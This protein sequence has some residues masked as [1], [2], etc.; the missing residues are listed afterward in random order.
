MRQAGMELRAHGH[1]QAAEEVFDKALA[2]LGSRPVQESE[3]AGHRFL[4]AWTLYGADRWEAARALAEELVAESPESMTY[5]GFLGL[6][7][8][9]QGDGVLAEEQARWL[10]ELQPPFFPSS[11]LVWRARIAS[12]S[13][14][15]D[16]AMSL[17]RQAFDR[18]FGWSNRHPAYHSFEPL[19]D[20]PEYQE[21]MRPTG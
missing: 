10:A 15:L 4:L 1:R 21:L 9:H 2:W 12:A 6:V 18:G 16:G 3:T 5:R 14:D 13:G 17:L 7:A 11:P 20:L 19:Y 8:A